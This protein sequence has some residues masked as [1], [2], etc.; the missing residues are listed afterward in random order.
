[1]GKVKRNDNTKCQQRYGT[2]R[3]LIHFWL[4]YEIEQSFWKTVLQ[5]NPQLQCGLPF[6]NPRYIY[7]EKLKTYLHTKTNMFTRLYSSKQKLETIQMFINWQKEKLWHIHSMKPYLMI[8][9]NT[10][11]INATTWM[12]YT[13]YLYS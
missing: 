3:N 10:I 2:F 12:R 1:M 7:Q 6:P 9:K 11:L 13:M 4:E 8:K 5:L